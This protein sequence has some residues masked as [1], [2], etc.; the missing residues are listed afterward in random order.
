MLRTLR[1]SGFKSFDRFEL[2][3]RPGLNIL[4]GPNGSGKT[5]II[6]FLEFLGL[7]TRSPLIEAIGRVGGAGGIFRRTMDGKLTHE[8]MF[9]IE[10]YGRITDFRS[11]RIDLVT[12]SYTAII[13][14]STEENTVVFNHQ[15]LKLTVTASEQFQLDLE[16]AE[17]NIDIETTLSATEISTKLHRIDAELTH[18]R[19]RSGPK[20]DQLTPDQLTHFIEDSC[21]HTAKNM[22]LFE[23]LDPFVRG[24][25]LV[26][27]DL[28]SARS[29][30]ITPSMVRAAE[31]IATEPLIKS[32]GSG[33]AATLYA[34]QTAKAR[35]DDYFFRYP[36][37]Y[38]YR[39]R[40]ENAEQMLKQIID[41]SKMVNRSIHDITVKSDPMESK[42]RIFLSIAYDSGELKLP[43]SLVSDG[44]AKWFTLVTAIV[45]NSNLFAIEEPENFLHPLMQIEIV[46]IVRNQY[47]RLEQDRFALIT[48][49]SETILNRC[50][51]TEIIIVEMKNGRTEAHRPDN[52][53]SVLEQIQETGFGL[54]YYYIT[55]A[56]E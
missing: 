17:N 39:P 31:D 14:L 56:V 7:L 37:Y 27:R 11:D 20:A 18:H 44:T 28:L 10:G 8:I 3:F 29:F 34:L 49:H 9:D 5:N 23:I 40:F 54:G 51:P 16:E 21:R 46:R 15:R 47:E 13:R 53:A 26:H 42:L 12:Y 38:H 4:V 19:L 48:T 55:G 1:C 25:T 2:T 50:Q 24:P 43:F 32:N 35:Q 6:L 45:T 33:L 22:C 52:A 36:T 41:Y 30:N